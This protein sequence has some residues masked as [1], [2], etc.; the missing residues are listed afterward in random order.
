MA[1]IDYHS[2]EKSEIYRFAFA[3]IKVTYA[4]TNYIYRY[5]QSLMSESNGILNKL[6]SLKN[7]VFGFEFIEGVNQFS[8][9]A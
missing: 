4:H 9:L 3:H 1:S 2:H 5:D 8:I 6:N 7:F